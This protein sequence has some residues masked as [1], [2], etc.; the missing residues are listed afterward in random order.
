MV[1]LKTAHDA[2]AGGAWSP[3]KK[4]EYANDQLDRQH[5]IA[6]DDGTNQSKGTHG[7][8]QWMPPLQSYWCHHAVDWIGIKNT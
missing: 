2:G 7:P 6:V 3:A 8:D 4:Q 1:P 5:L